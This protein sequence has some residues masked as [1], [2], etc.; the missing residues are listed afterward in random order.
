[1]L[2]KICVDKDFNIE[3]LIWLQDPRSLSADFS[4]S[5]T[6]SI[7]ADDTASQYLLVTYGEAQTATLTITPSTLQE[8]DIDDYWTLGGTTTVECY[9]GGSLIET[10]T[11]IFPQNIDS[12]AMLNQ[13]GL[14]PY[15]FYMTGSNDVEDLSNDVEQIKEDVKDLGD[16]VDDI[17]GDITD[18]QSNKQNFIDQGG[19]APSGTGEVGDLIFEAQAGSNFKRL[20]RYENNAYVQIGFCQ[21]STTDLTAGTSALNT[22]EVY[23]VYE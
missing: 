10:F 19:T 12:L 3:L 7:P 18:L 2:N 11:F 1:M 13:D 15:K 17:S 8:I 5:I 6:F 23:L 22:G 9:K 14:D 20:Y 16:D 21:Y 4:N